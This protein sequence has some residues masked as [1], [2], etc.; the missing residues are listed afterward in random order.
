MATQVNIKAERRDEPGKGPTKRL[1]KTGRTPA[2]VYGT[3]LDTSIAC[4]VDS[5]ELY[6]ALHTPAGTNVLIQLEIE[7]ETHLS[8]IR[9]IQRHAV[10]GDVMHVDFLNVSRTQLV[11][12]DIPVHVHNDEDAQAQGGV[13][14]IV[15]HS[16]PIHVRALET[17]QH[18]VVDLEGMTIGDSVR[19]EDLADQLP[20]G[21]TFDLEVDRT[22]VTISAP[23]VLEEP[24]EAVEGEAAEGAE[25]EPADGDSAGEDAD[26]E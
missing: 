21:A 15:L 20:E 9:D 1:R 16:V 23:T 24:E 3:D 10:R 13:V 14:S 26:G 5:L 17:P 8:I 22:V 11:P 19:L 4:H 7:G 12:A 18:F 2:I 25:G 6:H